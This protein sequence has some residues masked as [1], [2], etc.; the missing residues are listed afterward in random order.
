MDD[1][2]K[3][4]PPPGRG[5]GSERSERRSSQSTYGRKKHKKSPAT[6]CR[7]SG[8]RRPGRIC[9]GHL[10]ISKGD[11]ACGSCRAMRH[12]GR[13]DKSAVDVYS[14]DLGDPAYSQRLDPQEEAERAN[15]WQA[16]DRKDDPS[17][18]ELKAR[19]YLIAAHLKLAV[20]VAKKH[21]GLLRPE[22]AI[23]VCGEALIRSIDTVDLRKARLCTW[24]PSK[25]RES[26]SEE[27]FLTLPLIMIG[28]PEK[29]NPKT[30]KFESPPN[31]YTTKYKAIYRAAL[32]DH[33][34]LAD[35]SIDAARA[36]KAAKWM[37]LSEMERVDVRRALFG[38]RSFDAQV[39]QDDGSFSYHEIIADDDAD[40][41][42]IGNLR[43]G[44]SR[45]AVA[46][47]EREDS[48]ARNDA[49]ARARAQL[50]ERERQIID[51]IVVREITFK[52]AGTSVGIGKTQ[53]R[54]DYLDATRKLEAALRAEGFFVGRR[55]ISFLP[56]EKNI[57]A[58]FNALV[59]VLLPRPIREAQHYKPPLRPTRSWPWSGHGVWPVWEE[60]APAVTPE[61]FGDWLDRHDY[62][63][64]PPRGA[65]EIFIPDL[66][67]SPGR[68][69]V[70][71]VEPLTL[72]FAAAS[73]VEPEPQVLSF[74]AA[75]PEAVR[76]Y[77]EYCVARSD[78]EWARTPKKPGP[79]ESERELKR[80]TK[81]RTKLDNED[82]GA[83]VHDNEVWTERAKEAAD[84]QRSDP[85][86]DK[87]DP[88]EPKPN[89][90][91][92]QKP[93][94]P[95]TLFRP[96]KAEREWFG[97]P[98]ARPAAIRQTAAN[99]ELVAARRMARKIESSSPRDLATL[100]AYA[101]AMADLDIVAARDDYLA[102]AQ[103]AKKRRLTLWEHCRRLRS[104]GQYRQQYRRVWGPWSA[105]L[106]PDSLNFLDRAPHPIERPAE[107]LSP[108]T[109]V[110]TMA[111]ERARRQAKMDRMMQEEPPESNVRNLPIPTEISACVTSRPEYRAVSATPVHFVVLRLP[112]I[113]RRAAAARVPA[114][115]D[116]FWTRPGRGSLT[117]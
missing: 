84:S 33:Y 75:D 98:T 57:D 58:L 46:T 94:H 27:K 51:A 50:S 82:L 45:G 22:D 90:A 65:V 116:R 64:D 79:L 62:R 21:R 5:D 28:P 59:E 1:E 6:Y 12:D 34:A 97:L 55:A 2:E 107:P 26:L 115:L 35:D 56:G 111:G 25:M 74:R 32:D 112:G 52:A 63:L 44:V 109:Y 29:L 110:E 72:R 103:E 113:E 102:I 53:A 93:R 67:L 14:A 43:N 100:V 85:E 11:E 71:I 99:A 38:A 89:L 114:I 20:S 7:E 48:V 81:F 18:D 15:T 80:I 91:S 31:R 17:K 37:N 87:P 92:C 77:F 104:A 117:P 8:R 41:H 70:V 106:Q 42:S 24:A 69:P 54:N 78:R 19:N 88:G 96:T 83:F 101:A 10:V 95:F 86:L 23:Q 39:A 40:E 36:G 13:K 60:V 3:D 9:R 66:R 73:Q 61:N 30:G 47:G 4:P 76:V 16:R 49:I 108:R 105:R 68:T